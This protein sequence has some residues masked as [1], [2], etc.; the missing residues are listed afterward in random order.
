MMTEREVNET[1][2]MEMTE[3]FR[4]MRILP[5][6]VIHDPNQA[7]PLAQAL[8]EGGLPCAEVTYRTAS[9]EES[10]RRM[11][12]E[13]PELL[14]GAG[15]VLTPEQVRSAKD[16]GARFIVS[17]GFNPRVVD[18]CREVELPVFPG[19]ATPT[20]IEAALERGLRTLKFFPAEAMGGTR[21]LQAI[22]A[23]YSGVGFI[24]TGG[25]G[26][27]ELPAYLKLPSV[28]ACGGSWLA[29]SSWIGAGEFDRIREE[30]RRAV[31]RVRELT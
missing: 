9:A 22:T 31:E 23:P 29:P 18:A 15:T 5:V 13:V 28:V 19:V 7:A 1:R 11:S 14:V 16:A 2:E 27:E 6:I 12:G 3:H 25:I 26:L 20:E 17:P 21:F 4:R 30:T 10:L 8:I 24:P